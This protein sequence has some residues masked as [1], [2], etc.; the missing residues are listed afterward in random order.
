[1]AKGVTLRRIVVGLAVAALGGAVVTWALTTRIVWFERH[2]LFNYC[3]VSPEMAGLA[4]H[5]R[6]AAG[7]AGAIV[8][9][10]V[11]P[12]L[13]WWVGR[14]TPAQIVARLLSVLLA[15]AAAAGV[16]ELM[17]RHRA[18]QEVP[19]PFLRELPTLQRGHARYGWT[20]VPYS[21]REATVDGR[22]IEYAID[23]QGRRA[24][25]PWVVPDP[26]RP[27]VIVNGESIGFGHGLPYD[28]TLAALLERDLG[29]QVVN[30]S[31]HGY[32]TA[33]EY[34]RLLD[35][36]PKFS[37]VVA[38]V[39]LVL[40]EQ[41]SRDALVLE[42]HLVMG[43]DGTLELAPSRDGLRI[44]RLWRGEPLRGDGPL[45][46]TRAVLRAQAAAVTARGAQQLFLFTNMG[47]PCKSDQG[48]AIPWVLDQLLDG[49]HLP[50]VRVDIDPSESVSAVDPH[51]GAGAVRRMADAV[52][53]ALRPT[54]GG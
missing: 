31:V 10:V 25:D 29:V 3:V 13:A 8:M 5:L 18:A 51:P 16:A 7:I 35:E 43:D 44:A 15:I 39:T 24:R 36:L 41:I 47:G 12:L 23:A 46:L 33:Q 21:R 42:P 32:G 1:M 30:L 45:E 27:T 34:M 6:W 20:W 11:A 53:R 54:T 38:V 19:P 9:L 4:A 37:H 22:K 17:L 40:P 28:E 49:Q 2:L 50:Y 26:D 14:R 52:E 48:L